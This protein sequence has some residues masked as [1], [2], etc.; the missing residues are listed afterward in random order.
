MAFWKVKTDEDSVSDNGG[1]SYIM[2]SGMYDVTI[3]NAVVRRSPEDSG[4]KGMWIDLIVDYDGTVQT[5][6]RAIG[7][8]NNDGTPNFGEKLFNK[9]CVICGGKDGF[10]VGDPVAKSICVNQKEGKYETCDC[11]EELENNKVTLRMCKRYYKYGDEIKRSVDLKNVFREIDKASAAEIVNNDNIGNQY[12]RE[13]ETCKNVV[14][15]DVSEQEA[16]QFE[17]NKTSGGTAAA[18]SSEQPKRRFGFSGGS[19]DNKH[20][21]DIPF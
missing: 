5:I 8:V 13:L 10:D 20:T 7:M 14:Y 3:V 6:Y 19:E 12:V 9:L 17:A 11:I 18:K 1:G 16:A 4:K 21:D 15:K 2:D